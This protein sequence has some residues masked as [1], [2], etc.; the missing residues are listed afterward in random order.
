PASAELAARRPP[1]PSDDQR[2][3]AD[4]PAALLAAADAAHAAGRLDEAARL[5][6]GLLDRHAADARAPLAAF[7]LGRLLLT[8]LQRP[9]AP[10]LASARARALAPDGALAE[11]ALAREA[12]AWARAGDGPRARRAAAEYELRFP[13]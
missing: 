6:Q 4:G 5:L 2:A 9:A 12:E 3:D 13:S 8:R 10:A 7:T 1:R 11:D